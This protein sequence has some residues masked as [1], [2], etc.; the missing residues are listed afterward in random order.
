MNTPLPDTLLHTGAK[1]GM[2]KSNMPNFY[3]TSRAA[4]I[5][6]KSSGSADLYVGVWSGHTVLL[7][8][9]YL[10]GVS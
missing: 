5:H 8:Y 1:N 2:F 7:L 3:P 6:I 4:V 9:S 10:L